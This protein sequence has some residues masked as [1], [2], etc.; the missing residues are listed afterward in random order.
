MVMEN[1]N[2]REQQNHYDV[3]IFGVWSGCNYGSIA[4]YYALNQ[5]ISSMGKTVLM[6]DKPIL[7]DSDVELKETHARRFG[8]EHYNISKQYRLEQMHLLNNICDAFMIGSDQVWNYGISKNFGKAFY[9]D[10]AGEEKK[11]IAYAVSFGHGTDFAPV[12]ER[13]VIAEYMSYFDGIGTRE[14]DGVRLCRDCYGIKA[15]QVLDP[16]FVADPQIY[17]SLIEKSLYKEEEPFIAAYIL[18]PTPEKT[19]AILHLQKKFGG[20]KVINLLDGLPWLFEKNKKLTN[21][22]N[23]IENV[24]V[25]DWLYYLKNAQFVL[26]DSCHGASFALIFKKNFIA[27]TNR[28]RGFSRFVSLSQLFRFEDH[29]ITDPKA[30]LNNPD[31]LT[32][33]NYGLVDDIMDL[34]RRRCNKWLADVLEQPKKGEEDLKKQN[35]IG[36]ISTVTTH[37]IEKPKNGVC[38]EKTVLKVVGGK[39]CSGCGACESICPKGAITLVKNSEGFLVPSVNR[40]KCVTCGLC[41]KKC[42]SENPLY[43]NNAV[44][45][46]YAMMASDEIRKISSSGGMFTVAAEYVLNQGGYVCGAAYNK[47]YTVEHIIINDKSELGRLRGSKYMQSYS[48]G[49]FPRVKELLREGKIVL[50]TGMPCQVAGLYSYLGIEYENLYTIDLLCHG[51]TSSKVFEKYHKEV[52]EGKELARLEFKEKEP[53]GW[54]AGVNAYFSDGTKYSRPLETDMYFIAYLKSLAKN[55]ICGK[56]VSNKLPRQGDLTIGDFW[57]IANYDKEVYDKKGTSVVLVNNQKAVDFFEKL[58]PMM[59][60]V[61]EEPLAVAV[62]GNRII[63]GPYRLHKNREQFFSHFDKLD[64]SSLTQGCYYN[65]LYQYEKIELLK[66]LSEELHDYYYLAKAAVEYSQGRKIVTWIQSEK[67]QKVLK[68]CF[69]KEI[70]FFIA[71]SASRINNQTIFPMSK[72]SGRSSEFYIVGVDPSYNAELYKLLNN[73]GYKEIKD[74]IFRMPKPIVVEGYDC[75]KDRY[76]DAYGNTIEGY[77]GILGKVVFRGGNNHI[78]LGDKISGIQNL[79]FDLTANTHIEIGDENRFNAEN[80]FVSKGYEG[81]SRIIIRNNCRFTDALYRLY[82]S[83]YTS[84]ILINDSCTFESNIEFHAN[85]G[86][87]IVIGRDCM[88]SHDIDLWAGDGHSVFDVVTGKNVNS[89]YANQ[90]TYR[91]MIVIGEH[92]WVSKGSFIMHGTNVGNGSIIGAKSVVKGVFSNNCTISGNPACMVKQNSAWSRDMVTEN[93]ERCGKREYYALTSP[94]KAPIAGLKVLVIGGTRFM[95]IQ[96]VKKLIALGN[97]VTIATRGKKQDTFGTDISRVVMDVSDRESVALVLAGKSF[98]VVFD[99]LAYCSNYVDNVLSVVKCKKYVQLS[100][101]ETYLEKKKD[102][103]ESDFNP[104]KNPMKWVDTSAGYVVGKRQA[105]DA[106]YQRYGNLH[107]ITV[108]IP[109]VTKT[110]RLYYYCSHIINQKPMSIDDRSRGFTFVRDSEVGSFLAWIANQPYSGPINLASEGMVTIDEIIRYIEK[111]TN[112]CAIIDVLNG[113]KSPFHEFNETTFSMNMDLSKSLGYH[114]SKIDEWFWV[115]L[116]EYINRA[117]R[118]KSL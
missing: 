13:K 15:E 67:F 18:D 3:G 118:E 94:A 101:V 84:S 33:I 37:I 52:L 117:L 109:Y 36:E 2:V 46:C 108:R 88:F 86:K 69:D 43:K 55:T 38:D 31:L 85:S 28:H 57:G 111:K 60:K 9:L 29:L 41:L 8:R 113:D 11:K 63:E 79:S 53:W 25:E 35:I 19:E 71:K 7:S 16:V 44:P 23:C 20:I 1:I 50:F 56:C 100:S 22:P 66:T 78:I 32:P 104:L 102:L 96:L 26:T 76:V 97:D 77:K 98:D 114:T 58:K 40:N 49:I 5:V 34:E 54:H 48:S 106:L 81:K 12:D 21:L 17:D 107:G 4:T 47:D 112:Q 27:I 80:R 39:N 68:E 14:A 62:K 45:K 95:G 91:N 73:Y 82:N 59:T 65:K 75:S 10:F 92:V 83:E 70:A 64:F 89:V 116:D 6:I 90:E 42:T 105:E 72:I 99:N 74:F 24:Q 87:K 103:K 115:L 30:I 110:D 93:H 61:K 51:I